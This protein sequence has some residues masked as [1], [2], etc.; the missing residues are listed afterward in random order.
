[1]LSVVSIWRVATTVA[2][3]VAL[4]AAAPA[5]AAVPI[6]QSPVGSSPDFA[7][8]PA[9][10]NTVFTAQPP[11]D[12]FMAANQRS[13]IHVD[14]YQTDTNAWAGPLGRGMQRA[15][16]YQNADCASVGFDRA[17]RVVTAC[18]GLQ[19][20]SDPGAGLYMFDPRTLDTLAHMSLPPRQPGIGQNPLTDF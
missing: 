17:G 19:G 5:T 3:A 11:Q 13:E 18:I 14:A 12:P 16:T 1:M 4:V 7:G 10:Q 6:P 20:P 15:S 8:A 9:A 2:A